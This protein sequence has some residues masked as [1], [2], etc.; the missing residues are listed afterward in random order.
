VPRGQRGAGG[1]GP[2][3]GTHPA[4]G[5]APS[6]PHISVP[7]WN[8]VQLGRPCPRLRLAYC[9][10]YFLLLADI[11]SSTCCRMAMSVRLRRRRL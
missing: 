3:G 6:T 9:R 7:A 10:I 1:G 5:G 8:S 4:Q 2:A 11:A